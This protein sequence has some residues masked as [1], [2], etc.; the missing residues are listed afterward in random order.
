MKMVLEDYYVTTELIDKIG[1]WNTYSSDKMIVFQLI[2]KY[3]RTIDKFNIHKSK[4]DVN[5]SANFTSNIQSGLIDL[6]E[7]AKIAGEKINGD[8]KGSIDQAKSIL[9]ASA[10]LLP[11]Q[12][13]QS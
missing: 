2:K 7:A 4:I 5:S 6:T 12:D 9:K 8:F 3:M 11:Q 10:E 1:D 13:P